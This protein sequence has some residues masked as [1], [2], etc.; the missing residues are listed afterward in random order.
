[1]SGDRR[2]TCPPGWR[3]ACPPRAPRAAAPSGAAWGARRPGRTAAGQAPMRPESNGLLSRTRRAVRPSVRP[4]AVGACQPTCSCVTT[5]KKADGPNRDVG[6]AGAAAAAA[7]AALGS[8][9]IGR[10]DLHVV[11]LG[12]KCTQRGPFDPSNQCVKCKR[13]TQ[14]YQTN[15]TNKNSQTPKSKLGRRT[16]NANEQKKRK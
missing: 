11:G 16:T 9:S 4:D 1:M 8:G 3:H 2:R 5:S 12:N 13:K 15:K 10:F 6:R 14:K 7:A